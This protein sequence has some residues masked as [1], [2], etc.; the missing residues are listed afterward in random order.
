ML[1]PDT[2]AA[3]EQQARDENQRYSVK[4]LKEAL[5]TDATFMARFRQSALGRQALDKYDRNYARMTNPQVVEKSR[6]VRSAMSEPRRGFLGCIATKVS[7]GDIKSCAQNYFEPE[8]QSLQLVPRSGLKQSVYEHTGNPALAP[9]AKSHISYLPTGLKRYISQ[10]PDEY[11]GY[12]REK[13]AEIEYLK[14]VKKNAK[15][16]Q[17]QREQ[18]EWQAAAA[19][20]AARQG[21]ERKRGRAVDDVDED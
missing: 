2:V 12:I 13:K 14:S 1:A 16:E 21:R 18:E 8:Y 9:S 11:V 10:N 17:A 7:P 20:A 15:R 6:T 3:I 4:Y 19:A 5:A